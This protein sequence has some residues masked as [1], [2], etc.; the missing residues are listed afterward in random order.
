M[1]SIPVGPERPIPW[2]KGRKWDDKG[3]PRQL[4]PTWLRDF[5]EARHLAH[6]CL[7]RLRDAR[8]KA[9]CAGAEE[10]EALSNLE[11]EA[12]TLFNALHA[13]EHDGRKRDRPDRDPSQEA[14]RGVHS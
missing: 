6:E 5:G 8:S 11:R 12:F 4:L 9:R 10:A 3:R 7:K 13:W 2:E 1:A 14:G